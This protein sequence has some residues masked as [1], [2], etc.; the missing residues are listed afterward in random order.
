MKAIYK[1]IADILLN[2]TDLRTLVRYTEA[3]KNIRRAYVPQ[4]QWD[5]LVIFYL[6][7]ESVK[8]DFTPQIR[9]ASLILRVYD[10]EGDLPCD[11]MAERIILLLDGAD[12]TIKGQ[13]YVYDCSY[14]GELVASSWNGDLKS[15]EKV[16]RFVILF[17]VDGIVGPSGYPK[18]KRKRKWCD[19]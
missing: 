18:R 5:R 9:D 16:L 12:L 7:P 14:T 13:V 11:D 3:K 15:Y 4:G 10:R 8:T 2:D 19:E 1:A 6:Q 17:R